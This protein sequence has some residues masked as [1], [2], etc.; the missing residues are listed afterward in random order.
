MAPHGAVP[1]WLTEPLYEFSS[2]PVSPLFVYAEGGGGGGGCGGPNRRA[3]VTHEAVP[4]SS[5]VIVTDL[6]LEGLT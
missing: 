4:Y 1:D 6:S 2:P 5:A 3:Q